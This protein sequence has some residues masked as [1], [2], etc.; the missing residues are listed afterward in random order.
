[1]RRRIDTAGIEFRVGGAPMKR[2][3]SRKNPAQ[4]MTP[5]GRPIWVVKLNAYDPGVGAHGSTEAIWVEIAGPEPVLTVN[6]VATVS[7]LAHAPWVNSKAELVES[8]RADS[9]VM[10]DAS[11]VRAA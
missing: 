8:F 2:T 3:V 1:M 5:D 10:A 11:K 7:G 9:I 4:K 6:E